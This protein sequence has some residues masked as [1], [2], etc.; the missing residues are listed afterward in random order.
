MTSR[1]RAPARP[2]LLTARNS[3]MD[4][5]AHMDS[6]P[7]SGHLQPHSEHTRLLWGTSDPSHSLRDGRGPGVLGSNCH[8]LKWP[9]TCF[10]PNT[11]APLLPLSLVPPFWFYGTWP[12]GASSSPGPFQP[13]LW[14]SRS[15]YSPYLFCTQQQWTLVVTCSSLLRA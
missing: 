14:S 5:S 8:L 12:S 7:R 6:A 13:P 10:P 4:D 9:H 11:S 2:H 3:P 15:P 1:D